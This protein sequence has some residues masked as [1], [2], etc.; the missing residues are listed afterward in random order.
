MNDVSSRRML[1]Q[2]ER[3][4]SLINEYYCSIYLILLDTLFKP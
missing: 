3:M 2:I 1:S 4:L